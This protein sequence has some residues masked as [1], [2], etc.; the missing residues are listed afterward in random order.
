M[1]W[2][3]RLDKYLTGFSTSSHCSGPD[4]G[5]RSRNNKRRLAWTISICMKFLGHWDVQENQD[6]YF[7]AIMRANSITFKWDEINLQINI[8]SECPLFDFHANNYIVF[9]VLEIINKGAIL[10]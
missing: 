7:N 10:E 9:I 1:E 5:W 8:N 2:N 6:L 3:S 4:A